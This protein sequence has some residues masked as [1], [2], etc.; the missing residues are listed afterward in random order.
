MNE[1]IGIMDPEGKNLNPLTNKPYSSEYKRLAKIWSKYPAYEKADEIID[2]IKT[3][4]VILVVAGTGTG[5]T[6]LTP[7]LALHAL[8]YQSKIAICLPKQIIA[9]SAA[10]FSAMTLDVAIGEEVGYQYRGSESDS[11]S[12]KTKLLYATDGTIVSKLIN[13]PKLSEFNAVILDEAHERSIRIDLLLYLLRKTIE[14]RPEFK[15]IIMSATVNADIFVSY[16][17]KFKM[18]TVDIASKSNYPIESH[19]LTEPINPKEYLNKGYEILQEI[20]KK[21]NIKS[22]GAHDILFF[23]ASVNEANEICERINRDNLDGYCI[24]V[25]SGM[26]PE[27]EEIAKSKELYKNKT[28][29][30]RK[31]VIAT[32]VAE[33]SLTIDGLKYVIDSGYELSGYYDPDKEARVL[34]KKFV[35]Q[36]QVRQRI[37]RSGR[38]ESGIAYHLYTK[39]QYERMEEY[40]EPSIRTSNIYDECLRLLKDTGSTEKLI[41]T[42]SEFIEP[43]REKFIRSA[44]VQLRDL[45]LITNEG[46]TKLGKIIAE[47]QMDPMAGLAIYAG[48]KLRCSQEVMQIICIL[49]ACKSNL[50]ELF[51]SPTDIIENIPEN[52]GKIN[53]LM[54]K[55]NTAKEKFKNKYGD[56]IALLKIIEK[57]IEKDDNTKK[58]EFIYK[59]FL[60]KKVMD[61]A[62]KNYIRT[63]SS[64]KNNLGKV[65]E[66]TNIYDYELNDRIMAC[67]YYG[68]R[69]NIGFLKDKGYSTLKVDS[70]KASRD[71]FIHM[72]SKQP[73]HIFYHELFNN[74][75]KIELNIS[76]AIT[77]KMIEIEKILNNK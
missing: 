14:M 60:N 39:E 16:F 18:T 36:A 31:I 6:V 69:L 13:D 52:K 56:H 7:K 65:E 48:K 41:E 1:K 64:I 61:K 75:G 23:V 76:S 5:K 38:T 9:K 47:L 57:Y 3:N 28:T 33:S 67:L 68:F 59:Y 70:I 40:P 44:I 63:R 55:F 32:P 37:G 17:S 19:Y 30:S 51:K 11:K 22:K 8:N 58:T 72:M 10:D 74:N 43:P 24:E 54:N 26:D 12:N 4:Q 2:K 62:E 42:L 53:S 77:P 15:F 34:E 46:I 45:K 27:K 73:S 20:I 21:D 25:Y 50:N 29:K 66:I 71:S 49:E 35:S